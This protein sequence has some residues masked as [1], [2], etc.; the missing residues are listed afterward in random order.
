MEARSRNTATVVPSLLER[1]DTDARTA[2][3]ARATLL[4]LAKSDT[5]FSSNDPADTVYLL[6]RGRVKVYCLAAE[7][8]EL[9]LWFCVPGDVFGVAGTVGDLR[10]ACARA[11]QAS[12]V[13]AI[14]RERFREFLLRYPSAALEVLDAISQRVRTLSDT[15]QN[16]ATTCVTGRVA[17]LLQRLDGNPSLCAGDVACHDIPLTHQDIADMVGCCR[18]SVSETLGELKRSGAIFCGRNRVRVLNRAALQAA[19][20]SSPRP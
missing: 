2:L 12:E 10:G 3:R 15:V 13:L 7:G 19:T 6:T 17:I 5:L 8:K 16:L 11:C 18:Q 4:T 1:L 9:I 14:P 20:I